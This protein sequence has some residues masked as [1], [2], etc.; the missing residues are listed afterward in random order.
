MTACEQ[1]VGEAD[2]T[3]A[4]DI[5]NVSLSV[6]DVLVNTSRTKNSFKLP[7]TLWVYGKKVQVEALIDSGATTSFINSSVVES[8]NL[9]T[10][11][12]ANP[13][14]VFNAD[15]TSNKQG[16]IDQSVRAYVEIGPHKSTHQLLVADLGNKDLIIGMTY[17]RKH[18]PEID[19]AKGEWR[20]TR[21]P[22]SCSLGARKR[23]FV[24]EEEAKE[25]QLQRSD[26]LTIPLDELGEECVENPHIN[27][28]DTSD[29]EDQE[30]AQFVAEILEKDIEEED[31]DTTNWKQL[32][33][34]YLHEYGDVFSKRKS[35]RMPARKPY[36]HGIDFEE[37]A[38]LPKPAKLYPMSPQ[39]R[40]SLDQWIEEE[41][42]KGYIQKSKSPLAAPVFFV[43]KKDGSLRLV[44]D[45]RKL[46][47][48]TKKNRYP[49]PR[50]N[51][52]IDSLSQ[53]SIFT[54]I[55]LR[56]G[57][58][59]V[60]IRK[61]DEWKTAFTTHRGLF[62][63]KVMYFGFCN[64]PATFQAMMNDILGDLI[65]EGHV[66]V[67]LD[68]ILI[69]T[70]DLKEHRRI[71]QLVLQRLR[72]NDLFA[73]P[74]KCFFEQSSIE[75]LGMI[76]SQGHVKMD[77]AK[78]AGV[79]DW[80]A[81]KKVKQVQAFL[82]FANFYRRFIKDFAKFAR[83][84]TILTRKDQPWVW[85]SEQQEAF[86]GLKKA[87]TSAPILRIPDDVNPFRLETDASDFATGAV[88][89]QLDPDDK[90]WHPVAFYSKSLNPAE[91]NY[92]IYDKELLAIIRALEEYRQHLEGHPERIEIWSD[93]QN[94]TYFKSTQKLTRRQ[95]RWALYLTRF[96]FVLKHKPGK[97]MLTADPLS[98]RPDHEEGVN[99][100]NKDQILLKPEFFAIS[101]IDASHESPI[102]DDQLL[103]EVKEALLSDDVVKDYQ[104]LLQS[105]PREFKK[106]LQE[107]NYENGLLLYRGKIYI[108]KSENDHLRRRIVQAH[109]DLPLAGHPGRWKT[110]ELVSRNYWWPGMTTYVKN[111]VT[112]CDICQR[113]K[114][115]PQQPYGPLQP[116][117]VPE[118]PWEIITIDLITQLPE[119]NGYNAICVV[120]DRFTKRAHFFPITNEF[121]A[122]DLA[123]LLYERVWTQHGLPKQIISD[124]GTQFAASIFQEWC[125]MLG[126]ESS[127]STSYHPQT[128]GQ[129]ERVNQILEQ[130]LRCYIDYQ[131]DNWSELLSSAEFAYN[132][133]AHEGTKETPFFLEYGRH[134]RAGPTL[135]KEVQR[136]DLND[137]MWARNQAQEQA[138]A[139]L[140][141][142]AERMKW[143]YDQHVQKVPFKEGDKVLVD[144]RDYQKTGRKLTARYAGPFKI[145][146]KLSPVTFRLEWPS[147]LTAIHPVFHASKLLPYHDST[148][149][150]QTN[151]PPP[152]INI[153]GELE[154][155][156]E[157]ILSS[158]RYRRK[159]QFLVRWKGYGPQDDSW[160]PASN[161][162][163]SPELIKEYYDA[164]P[165]AVRALE[166]AFIDSNITLLRRE[167]PPVNGAPV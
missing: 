149:P 145:V 21:C 13:Y 101:A 102:N 62:E 37:G 119:S 131:S 116:N 26:P 153:D 79:L 133:A 68:D 156:V 9:V 11:K 113:M 110:Y 48:I 80:P 146:E 91:R 86:E 30:I 27:W 103:R 159:L 8:N 42:R 129:T 58:N 112:G 88:L 118:G 139:A 59:N 120:V 15:G 23:E 24:A 45:Y 164:H 3:V 38:S 16:K 12:L 56:W 14:V 20:Y 108:P 121:S 75:Y 92:E 115:H 19:W 32:V 1:I 125:R 97:T 124:R 33:P 162:A 93:H 64:A 31:E 100:D 147:H 130:Y 4:M 136:V 60:R 70:N 81:P 22:E 82:G 6:P 39:E 163:N 87:F 65:L 74:E 104:Q 99:F 150:G 155:E 123:Q 166:E 49:I 61:G 135:K 71:T 98:R 78:L 40:N 44:Q 114:N 142:A 138:K 167:N 47:D 126:I 161:L 134:P 46:N 132:N 25:L 83:P 109:H 84:L 160:E 36:D 94:L 72:D 63:A 151:P 111:Y 154:Y 157:K 143:Y 148:I 89:S 17:L 54:K 29:P 105:G 76:I 85:G 127:M 95:A 90:L 122:K 43:K 69:F 137:I 141:L 140:K 18:N 41:L 128:D 106:S 67:Y 165:Q 73:K 28:V 107:W 2:P 52:L 35:E 53:A 152:P 57:Y 66:I 34:E 51:D 50:I 77:P 5:C 10:H 117:E 96:N 7:V 55:D 144:L 158:R